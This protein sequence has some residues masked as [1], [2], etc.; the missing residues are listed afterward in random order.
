M[1]MVEAMSCGL[2]V[3]I[4]DDADIGDVVRNGENGFL[5]RPGDLDGF[6]EA[7]KMVLSY[8]DLYEKL[9]GGALA[10]RNEGLHEYSLDQA[11]ITW[12][13]ALTSCVH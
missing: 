13:K 5:I 10:I 2:P 3:V 8:K 1:A 11:Q 4:F 6:A 12:D 9:S 7:V